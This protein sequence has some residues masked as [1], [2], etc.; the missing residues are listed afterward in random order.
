MAIAMSTFE[1][2]SILWM[3]HGSETTFNF[4]V[5][6][7]MKIKTFYSILFH[8]TGLYSDNSNKQR[9]GDKVTKVLGLSYTK[10]TYG[11]ITL[12]I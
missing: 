8:N 2:F 7:T 5:P 12:K 6:V 4:V 11:I 9:H 3:M 10:R 1:A